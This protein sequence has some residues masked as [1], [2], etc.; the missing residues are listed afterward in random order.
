VCRI[1]VNAAARKWLTEAGFLRHGEYTAAD[2]Q[3]AFYV[4]MNLGAQI[5]LKRLPDGTVQYRRH[6]A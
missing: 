6:H 2:I 5:E 1:R 4:L 3:T